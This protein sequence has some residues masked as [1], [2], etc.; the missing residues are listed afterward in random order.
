MNV[1]ILDADSSWLVSCTL[2]LDCFSIWVDPYTKDN[3]SA[4]YRIPR[5]GAVD[6]YGMSLVDPLVCLL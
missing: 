6:L 4:Y 3:F 1:Q 2:R 5:V